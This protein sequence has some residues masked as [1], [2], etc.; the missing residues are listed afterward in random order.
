[1]SSQSTTSS[2]WPKS[3]GRLT[4]HRKHFLVSRILCL[5]AMVFPLFS[6]AIS[7]ESAEQLLNNACRTCHTT[8]E[9]DNR[10]GP[11][12][13]MIIGRKAG[14]LPHYNYSNAMKGAGFIWDEEKLEQFIAHPDD[15]VPG[16]NMKPYGGL[17]SAEDRTRVIAFLRSMK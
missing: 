14:S 4:G 11:N 15:V 16:N 2:A 7:Q 5:S 8:R 9:D 12:L 13:H 10:L 1:M 6:P 3:G 17:T